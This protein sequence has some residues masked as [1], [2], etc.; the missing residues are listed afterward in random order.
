MNPVLVLLSITVIWV[1]LPMIPA[2]RELFRPEDLKP[3]QLTDRSVG[4]I[5]FFARNFRQYLDRVLPPEAGAGDYAARLLDDTQFVRVNR[6]SDQLAGKGEIEQRLV[7]IDS[8]LTLAGGQT[9]AMEVYAREKLSSGP[10]T[11]YR[12]LYGELELDLGENTRVFRWAHARGTLTVGSHSVLRGRASSDRRVVLGRDV[13]FERLS[14][15][16]IGCGAT[17]EPPPLSRPATKWSP[18]PGSRVLGDCLRVEGDLDL[19]RESLVPGNLVVTGRLR[20]GAGSLVEGSVKAHG[21]LELADRARVGG[22]A[23]TRGRLALSEQAWIGGPA[24]AE[25]SVRLGRDSVVGGPSLPA[26]VCGAEV[27]L[28]EGATV[29]GQISATR[30][31]RTL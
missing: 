6:K 12:A 5:S 25:H 19:P 4:K 13:V 3:I 10:E 17:R 9:F 31:A 11:N 30:G 7:V 20:I 23:I 15:P 29:Y 24:V 27:E 1:L 18:P 14:A 8:P 26:S 16:V 22:A 2:L 28:S 21:D